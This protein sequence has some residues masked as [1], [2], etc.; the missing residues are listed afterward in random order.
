M[1]MSVTDEFISELFEGTNFG[2]LTN[3]SISLKRALIKRTLQCQLDSY[4][5]G[6]TAYHIV[7]DGG[8]LKD[9]KSNTPKKLTKLGE[10]F[11]KDALSPTNT[12]EE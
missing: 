11:M 12:T 10:D 8:F 5:S 3:G 1:I 9:G 6:H 7:V 4:W 2:A